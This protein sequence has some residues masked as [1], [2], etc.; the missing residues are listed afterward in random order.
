MVWKMNLLLTLLILEGSIIPSGFSQDF[1][2]IWFVKDHL[3]ISLRLEGF[4]VE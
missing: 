1:S 4:D 2:V 3:V